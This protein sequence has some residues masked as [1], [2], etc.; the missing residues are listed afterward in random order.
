MI[1]KEKQHMNLSS[2]K[3]VMLVCNRNYTKANQPI[4]TKLGWRMGLSQE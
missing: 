1:T 3:E 2:T 4:S